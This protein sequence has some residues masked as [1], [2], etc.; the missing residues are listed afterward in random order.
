MTWK[1]LGKPIATADI[2]TS[3]IAQK[4]TIPT[5]DNLALRGANVGIIVYN[6]PTLTSLSLNIYADDSG[7]PGQLIAT[8]NSYTKA[9]LTTLSHA[10]KVVGF[11][12]ADIPLRSGC[13][14]FFALSGTGYTGDSTAHIAWRNSYPD[15]QFDSGITTDAAHADNHPLEICLVA[16]KL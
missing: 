6:S 3:S 10:F 12:F 8:S 15:P 13:S 4:V 14:Y 7:F 9:E 1:M 2:N 11:T 16:S 5:G